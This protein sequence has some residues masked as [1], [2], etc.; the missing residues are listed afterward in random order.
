M[1][2]QD[3]DQNQQITNR[4][5]NFF[6]MFP[7]MV[8]DGL[9]DHY[10]IALYM[11]Y[12]RVCG[13]KNK[14]CEEAE[15]TTCERLGMGRTKFRETRDALVKKQAIRIV[16]EGTPNGAGVKGTATKID[17]VDWYPQNGTYYLKPEERV[18]MGL[19]PYPE[20][21]PYPPKQVD[22][23]NQNPPPQGDPPNGVDGSNENPNGSNENPNG[24]EPDCK[25]ESLD[26]DSKKLQTDPEKV[27]EWTEDS[28]PEDGKED[29]SKPKS[30]AE[31]RE[32][33]KVAEMLK[34]P[35]RQQAAEAKKASTSDLTA[36]RLL[37][38][39]MVQFYMDKVGIGQLIPSLE[40]KFTDNISLRNPDGSSTTYQGGLIHLWN[41]TPGFE[42]FVKQ[43][44]PALLAMKTA[45]SPLNLLNNLRNLNKNNSQMN[46]F[47]A[48]RE[49]NP[50]LCQKYTPAPKERK[51]TEG[52]SGVDPNAL[53]PL[54]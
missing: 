37:D 35:Q 46:G 5:R 32:G 8:Y 23:P 25:L 4:S 27:G 26:S 22:G 3:N 34:S 43:R 36:S 31:R 38:H 1:T 28:E 29:A 15:R 51:V 54:F 13:R 16:E 19:P 2:T 11:H 39:P 7:F 53:V 17:I 24:P 47:F 20:K 10:E 18:A 44:V 49:A 50:Q 33:V 52:G 45:I 12:I 14:P 21:W 42:T 48:W 40:K 41:H 6:G 9:A 30:E